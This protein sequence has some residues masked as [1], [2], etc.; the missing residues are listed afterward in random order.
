MKS[1]KIIYEPLGVLSTLT[2]WIRI[3]SVII[4]TGVVYNSR[5]VS[6]F[7]TREHFTFMEFMLVLRVNS[8]AIVFGQIKEI[9]AAS[10]LRAVIESQSLNFLGKISALLESF[11]VSECNYGFVRSLAVTEREVFMFCFV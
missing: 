11:N 3:Q 7:R 10:V 2:D 9:L 4:V 6:I 8:S 5:K 1:R